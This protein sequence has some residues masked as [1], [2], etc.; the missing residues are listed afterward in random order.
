MI[1]CWPN[2]R[3]SC[4]Y[5]HERFSWEVVVVRVFS[6]T[7]S[8]ESSA[9]DLAAGALALYE[10]V[11]KGRGG[12]WRVRISAAGSDWQTIEAI[13]VS[14]LRRHGLAETSIE[15][16]PSQQLSTLGRQSL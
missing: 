2:S 14:W 12:R 9:Q 1:G 11:V 15:V 4:R 5:H 7:A 13:V 16:G 10:P 6:I 8:D 3:R